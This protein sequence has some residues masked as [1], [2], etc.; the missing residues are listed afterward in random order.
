[1]FSKEDI[2]K[3]LE[4]FP[5]A[6]PTSTKE[7]CLVRSFSGNHLVRSDIAR[8]SFEQMLVQE[9]TP[10]RISSLANALGIESAHWLLEDK[11][12]EVMTSRDG[13]SILPQPVKKAIMSNFSKSIKTRFID[14]EDYAAREGISSESLEQLLDRQY[15][16]KDVGII[17]CHGRKYRYSE[18]LM[19]DT[20][21][22]VSAVLSNGTS[23]N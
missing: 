11:H 17:I 1:M 3:L 20:R 10:I 2:R 12:L 14:Q 6:V 16:G 15:D 19:E 22:S 5:P 4:T 21:Q 23:S 7:P 18:R 8:R 9:A 13:Q